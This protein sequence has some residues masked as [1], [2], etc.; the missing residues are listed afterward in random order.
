M[1]RENEKVFD[2]S[3]PYS[4]KWVKKKVTLSH[5]IEKIFGG[6]SKAPIQ[7]FPTIKCSD[8]GKVAHCSVCE[9]H[10]DS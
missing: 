7:I 2:H 3:E 4:C 10:T 1:G 9:K 5:L 6:E 8:H